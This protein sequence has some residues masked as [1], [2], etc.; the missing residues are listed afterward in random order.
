MKT[1]YL[2]ICLI[3]FSFPSFSEI[4]QP[5]GLFFIQDNEITQG[6]KIFEV[7][8]LKTDIEVKVQGL[9]TTTTVRQYFIN[10]TQEHTEA[11]YLFPLP[12]KSLVDHLQMKIGDRFINGIIEKKEEAE[13]IYQEAKQSG[14][15][16]SLV[17]SS[18][19]NIFKTKIANIQPGE[20]I[21]VE[22]QYQDKL[23][24]KDD[25]YSIRIPT[26]IN[27]R[28]EPSKN[29]EKVSKIETLNPDLHSPINENNSYSINPYSINIDLNVGFKITKPS[30]NENINIT[31]TSPTHYSI[32]LAEGSMPS[33][34]DFLVTFQPISSSEPYVE[35]YG[36]NVGNDF[37]VYGLVNPQIH[38]NFLELSHS[39]VITIIADVSGSMSGSS[40]DQLKSVLTN[41][42]YLLPDTYYLNIIAFNDDHYKLF[43][44]PE[45]V[46]EVNKHRALQ[47]VRNMHA[48]SGTEMLGPIYEALFEKSP[49]QDNHQII[50]MTDGAVSNEMEA[51][52]MVN[53][54]IGNKNLHVVAIGSAPNSYLAKGLAKTGRGS[55]LYVNNDVFE[56]KAEELFYKINRP[57]LKNLRVYLDKEH[58]LLPKKLPDVLV[59]EPISFFIKIPNISKE[60]LIN[61][62][63]IGGDQFLDYWKFSINPDEIQEGTNINKLWA[64]EKIDEIMFHNAI[65]FLDRGTYENKVIKLALEHNLVTEFTSLVAVDEEITRQASD[66]LNSH[67]IA[68]NIPDGWVEP[69]IEISNL[70]KYQNASG[71]NQDLIAL[72]QLQ[73]IDVNAVPSLQIHFVQTDTLKNLYYIFALMFLSSFVFLF[74]CR[75][76]LH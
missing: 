30:S 21:I 71:D 50:L 28:Y 69:N 29:K 63:V 39:S 72:N 20:M 22:I 41:F 31:E 37:Y 67:Q 46:N 45:I 36:E 68:H 35:I 9:L 17:S 74:I 53:E 6:H 12:D 52:A 33:T 62:I 1:L 73:E 49:L 15:K 26:V 75:R 59:G 4:N 8:T 19:S 18:R 23:S 13:K 42:I 10:P 58:L 43:K 3:F 34:K 48:D 24:F 5:Y 54:H 44:K 56:E 64:K 55:F 57:V 65:G 70:L 14:K 40:I 32:S 11:I 61:P 16:T 47:F 2:S 38:S 76:Q 27:H 25:E 7:P 66:N 60:D 51:V